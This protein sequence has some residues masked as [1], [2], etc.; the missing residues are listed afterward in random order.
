MEKNKLTDIIC[1]VGPT[2]SGKSALGVSLSELFNGEVVSADS[3]QI[4]KNMSISTAKPTAYE[5]R[6]IKHHM[7]GFLSPST[8]YSVAEYVTRANEIIADICARGKTPVLVGG[9]G[10]YVKSLLENISFVPINTKP[11]VRERLTVLAR[12]K[13]IDYMLAYLGTFDPRAAGILSEQRN[14]KRILRA[15]EIY[16]T[17]G[18]TF[19]QV[20]EESKKNGTFYKPV[21]IGLT[22][23]ER[24][25]LYEKIN[26]RVDKMLADGLVEEAREIYSADLG[27]TAVQAIGCKEFFPYFRGERSLQEC[28]E[29][30]KRATR[31]YAKRQLTWFK[32]DEE[33]NWIYTDDYTD[34]SA[35]VRT[36]ADILIKRGFKADV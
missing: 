5:M 31:R 32:R 26:V 12:D 6:G 28:I 4:Y 19:T 1:V 22:C 24:L 33:I 34:S 17:T 30:L 16:E 25:K 3:M 27:A 7:I 14:L 9:T 10:L 8:S 21:K 20:N 29:S 2:A 36:A 18:K 15:I 13:G 23:R 35:V 11:E